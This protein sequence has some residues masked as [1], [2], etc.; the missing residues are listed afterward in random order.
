VSE[1]LTSA[2]ILDRVA[3]ER[4][5]DAAAKIVYG[6]RSQAL[7]E[8]AAAAEGR[9]HYCGE[10]IGEVE[11]CPICRAQQA[12]SGRKNQRGKNDS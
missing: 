4:K 5:H 11:V 12:M 1:R 7:A 8:Y 10:R 6:G 3:I 2:A 9:C